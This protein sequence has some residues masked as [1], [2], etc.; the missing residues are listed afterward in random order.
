MRTSYQ[1]INNLLDDPAQIS[2]VVKNPQQ[3][4]M[5]FWNELSSQ[6]KSYIAMAAGAALVMYGIYL[7]RQTDNTKPAPELNQ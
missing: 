6:H 2:E 1:T 4:G 7:N 5:D 3:F